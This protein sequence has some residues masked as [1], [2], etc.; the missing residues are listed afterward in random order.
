[1]TTDLGRSEN[2]AALA[3]QD[4]GKIV[5]VGSAS[6]DPNGD[7]DFALARYLPDGSLDSSFGDNGHVFTPAG[8]ADTAPN[9]GSFNVVALQEDGKILAAG[10]AALDA[11]GQ[12]TPG[13]VLARYN[14]DGSLDTSF[15]TEGFVQAEPGTGSVTG[16]ELQS[17]GKMVVSRDG[18]SADERVLSLYTADGQLD[19]SFGMGGVV[20][21]PYRPTGIGEDSNLLQTADGGFVLSLD[22]RL[23]RLNAAGVQDESFGESGE[24]DTGYAVLALS[25]QEDGSMIVG[26]YSN[27]NYGVEAQTSD[28]P[29]TDFRLT[30]YTA[31]GELDSGFGNAGVVVT[32]INKGD[33]VVHLALQNDG[34][35]IA[36]GRTQNAVA[37]VRYTTA[38]AV[39]AS[40]VGAFGGAYALGL[41]DQNRIV[42]GGERFNG[43]IYDFSLARLLP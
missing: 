31:E 41:D 27:P 10:Y 28:P 38:G 11:T 24:V 22:T 17:D 43:E 16:L 42:V 33:E 40:F 21:L 37:V 4:D 6:R 39:D 9:Q 15:G 34:K 7:A 5:A 2:I 8:S 12:Y 26:Q 13:M 1:M 20:V 36:A 23:V 14:P 30:R 19:T 35:I 25:Q 32:D 18:W 29:S 3:L